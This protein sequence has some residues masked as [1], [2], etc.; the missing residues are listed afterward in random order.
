[1]DRIRTSLKGFSLLSKNQVLIN[2]KLQPEKVSS[3]EDSDSIGKGNV[4]GQEGE[5]PR[6]EGFA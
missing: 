4:E 5:F 3:E 1:M 2:A 6:F